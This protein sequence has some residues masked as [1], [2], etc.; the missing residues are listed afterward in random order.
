MRKFTDKI[1]IAVK[2]RAMNGNNVIPLTSS[3]FDTRTINAISI[4]PRYF[5]TGF[6]CRQDEQP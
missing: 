1:V 4:I 2:T 3:S 6:F 5:L